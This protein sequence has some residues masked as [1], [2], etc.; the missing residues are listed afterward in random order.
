VGRQ[1]YKFSSNLRG[2]FQ[3]YN[4]SLGILVGFLFGLDAETIQQGIERVIVPGRF[5]TF[6]KEGKVGNSRLCPHA[7]CLGEGFDHLPEG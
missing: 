6:F 4:L 2:E 3:A 1:T 5:E 7:R